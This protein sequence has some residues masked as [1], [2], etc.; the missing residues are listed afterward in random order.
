MKGK[1]MYVED[2]VEACR[3]MIEFLNPRGFAVIVSF[4]A[5]EAYGLLSKWNPD[6]ILIDIKLIGESGIDFIE[7]I[8]KEGIETPVIIITAYPKRV[9]EIEM[10]GLKIYGYYE[11]PFSYAEL[12]K[13][14]IDILEVT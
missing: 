7:R 4:T 10:R 11:K 6:L 2:E 3:T 13:S 8:Q 5:E 14:V 9:A 12:Y 1:I